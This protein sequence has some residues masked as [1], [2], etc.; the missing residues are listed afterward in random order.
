MK[1]IKPG[2]G[3]SGISFVGSV[4]VVIFGI[5]WTVIAGTMASAVPFGIVSI[6]PLFGVIFIIVGIIQAAYHYKNATGK[7]RFSIFD[8]T[9]SHE[10]GDPADKWIKK[11]DKG[12][13]RSNYTD[14]KRNNCTDYERNNYAE[15]NG[16]WES[17]EVFGQ[18][19]STEDDESVNNR[20]TGRDE[21]G[22]GYNY[23]PFCGNP[24]KEGFSYC[25]GC[26]KRLR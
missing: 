21:A 22:A 15:Y 17:G 12:N 8:I 23:C 13:E 16:S 25:P 4:A 20:E 1:S 10:E 7:E 2:R 3:P 24:L 5:I 11:T 9:D 6:F 18:E 26:G 19:M 14:Y